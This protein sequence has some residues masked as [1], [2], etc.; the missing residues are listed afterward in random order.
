MGMPVET[1]IPTYS[2]LTPTFKK[3]C[4]LFILLGPGY[5]I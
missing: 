1:Y 4:V 3:E 5:L 2:Q